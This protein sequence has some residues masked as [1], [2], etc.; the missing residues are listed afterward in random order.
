MVPLLRLA[1]SLDRAHQQ[2]VRDVGVRVLDGAVGLTL[3]AKAPAKLEQW[4][5][6]RMSDVFEKIYARSLEC[7]VPVAALHP[8]MTKNR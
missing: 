3:I 2:R 4:A 8:A 1:D 5:V 7:R 6:Q